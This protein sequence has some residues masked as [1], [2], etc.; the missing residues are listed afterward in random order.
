[1]VKILIDTN[2]WIDYLGGVAEASAVLE[3][4]DD[5]G[6]SAITYAEV[7]SGCTPAELAL[8]ESMLNVGRAL[9]TIQIIHTNDAIIKLAA[10]Y[11]HN[12]ATGSGHGRKRLPDAIIGATAVLTGRTLFTRNAH[13]FKQVDIHTPYQ[14]QWIKRDVNGTPTKTWVPQAAV[15]P[16]QAIEPAQPKK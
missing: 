2:I 9:G 8:F 6:M 15:F 7:A 5:V 4:S 16:D 12:S 3:N 10:A 14:G 13:D 1:M 11:N